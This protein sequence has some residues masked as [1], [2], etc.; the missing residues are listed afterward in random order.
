MSLLKVNNWIAFLKVKIRTSCALY[1][2][3]CGLES[4]AGMALKKCF[5]HAGTG[6][7]KTLMRWF[8]ELAFGFKSA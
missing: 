7:S 3:A 5:G 1:V 8:A 4:M 6:P 2:L